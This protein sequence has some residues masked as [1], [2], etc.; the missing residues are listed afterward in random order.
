MM[1]AQ[2]YDYTKKHWIVSVKSIYESYL[3]KTTIPPKF[4]III[5]PKMSMVFLI[6]SSSY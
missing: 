3:D 4:T 6:T 2:L 1:E 5:K